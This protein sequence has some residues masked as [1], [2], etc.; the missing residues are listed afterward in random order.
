MTRTKLPRIVIVG[1]GFG[2]LATARGLADCDAE[3]TLVDRANHHLFQ[4]LL[5]QVAMAGLSPADI[6][7]P[8]RRVL[9]HQHN[10]RVLLAEVH[11]LDL[12]ERRLRLDDGTYL[13]FDYLVLALGAKTNFF[14]NEDSFGRH[15]LGLKTLDEAVEIRRRVLSAFEAA[16]READEEVRRRLLTFVII[17]GG[18]TGVEL[19]GALR[20]L[21]HTVL[22]DDFRA[23]NPKA[24]RVV[25]VERAQRLLPGAFQ[26]DLA[27]SAKRQL[28]ELGV[29]VRL[30]E[31]VTHID[32][33]GVTVGDAL[34]PSATVIWTAGV[35]G[36]GLAERLGVEVDASARL[37]V[38]PDCSLPGHPRVFAI[39]DVVRF[40][41]EGSSTPLPG[42]APVAVQQGRHTAKNILR[43]LR[44]KPTLPFHYVD[45]G[46]MATI[47]R[48]R[49]VAQ[50][51]GGRLRL[52]GLA[53]WLAWLFVHIWFLIDFRNRVSVILNWFWAY[54]T[55]RRGARLITGPRPWELAERLATPSAVPTEDVPATRPDAPTSEAVANP[56]R[57]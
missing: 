1:G 38:E 33:A 31:S 25:L 44:G 20:D 57:V 5:Y 42:L 36:V 49:A 17:G 19:A 43:A 53:A 23:I 14:G 47:G 9:R 29:E 15:A 21:A 28:E 39:G 35:R 48:S 12:S 4:P 22:A 52:S 41:P 10:L 7:V 55:Y 26:D 6:A 46:I 13:S 8:I 11:A 51:W 50:T 37:I 3:I 56:P 30:G 27:E 34:L 45:K 18:A 40:V 16:E 32:A 54:I 2:G 24:A